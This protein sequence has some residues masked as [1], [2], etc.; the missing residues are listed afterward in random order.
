LAD[1]STW[2]PRIRATPDEVKRLEK[3]VERLRK[4]HPSI[5]ISNWVREAVELKI[6][7]D[8]QADATVMETAKRLAKR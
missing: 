6:R 7:V 3:H 4:L 8:A 1:R 5:N 2:F